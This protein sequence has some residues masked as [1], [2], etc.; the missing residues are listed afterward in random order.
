MIALAI[1]AV[2]VT[3][4]I[5]WFGSAWWLI[6]LYAV[7][8]L[9]VGSFLSVAGHYSPLVGVVILISCIAVIL[10]LTPAKP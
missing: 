10:Y 1:I 9:I 4:G 8:G 5:H 7:T 2:F 3:L 6:I